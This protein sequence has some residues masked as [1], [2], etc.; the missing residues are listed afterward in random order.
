MSSNLSQFSSAFMY[1]TL[2][3]TNASRSILGPWDIAYN[4]I[5]YRRDLLDRSLNMNV[6]QLYPPVLVLGLAAA[7]LW[8]WLLARFFPPTRRRLRQIDLLVLSLWWLILA[9]CLRA[10][11]VRFYTLPPYVTTR[12]RDVAH[13]QQLHAARRI[14][15]FTS[16][17]TYA[18]SF[19]RPAPE[20]ARHLHFSYNVSR[21]ISEMLH[22]QEEEIVYLVADTTATWMTAKYCALDST[23]LSELSYFPIVTYSSLPRHWL[24]KLRESH[25]TVLRHRLR[26]LLRRQSKEGH[27]GSKP[28]KSSLSLLKFRGVFFSFTVLMAV[29]VVCLLTEVVIRRIHATTRSLFSVFLCCL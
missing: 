23:T 9:H 24:P 10:K 3:R 22:D 27:C 16:S 15:I 18:Q 12:I 8:P 6:Y 17:H 14:H 5:V 19:E 21:V 1:L 7:R 20:L 26:R 28:K 13:L 2:A 11:Y 29:S 25:T 4:A